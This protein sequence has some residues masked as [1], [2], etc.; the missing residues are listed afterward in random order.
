MNST[1]FILCCLLSFILHSGAQD[2]VV[3]FE[4]IFSGK[5]IELKA[6][7]EVHL[8]FTVRDTADA[9]LDIAI[10]DVTVFG[11][12]ES[13]G[14]SSVMLVTKN[15]TVDRISMA[16]PV[17]SIEAFRKYSP[18][19]PVLKAATTIAAAA[20]GILVS[21]QIANSDQVMSWQ[22][23]GLAVGTTTAAY[24]SRQFFS[25]KMKYFMVEGWR[26]RVVSSMKN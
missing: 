13:V 15:K 12:I 10:A 2:R 9:P 22:N 11:T 17:N 8:R 24:M 7:D 6:G 4:N 20:S 18:L 21:M 16:V 26:G 25:D 1:P 3:T 14:D 19:R 5:K 23:A